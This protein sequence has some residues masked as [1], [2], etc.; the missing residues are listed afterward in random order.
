[1]VPVNQNP[2]GVGGAPGRSQ[3]K[4]RRLHTTLVS[5]KLAQDAGAA[6]G[7]LGL[8]AVEDGQQ[9]LPHLAGLLAR[10]DSLPDAC[11]LVV[12]N[13]GGGL[14]VVGVEALLEGVGVVVGPLDQG[15]AREVIDHG[16]LGRVEGG[17]VGAAR[18]RVDQAAR[19][20]RHQ[21]GVV[22]L[23]LHSVLQRLVALPEHAVEALCLGHGAGEAVEDESAWVWWVSNTRDASLK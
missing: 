12:A 23:Q 16:F 18:G 9:A 4:T 21:E 22:D 2:A 20:A 8:V 6:G 17:V 1:M 11:L 3:R 19:N 7:G 13:H 15:L 14:L 10:V 5:S